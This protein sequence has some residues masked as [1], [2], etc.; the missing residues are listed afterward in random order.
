MTTTSL[1]LPEGLR[2]RVDKLAAARGSSAHS[3]MVDAVARIAEQEERRL[4]FEAEAQRRWKQLLRKGEYHTPEAMRAYAMALARGEKPAPPPPSR[5]T[6][7]E[8][9][10]LRASARRLGDA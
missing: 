10:R 8:L 3:F 6:T 4:E 9:K 5:M 7:D 2:E 1:R